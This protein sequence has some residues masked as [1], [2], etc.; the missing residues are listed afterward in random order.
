MAGFALASGCTP[1]RNAPVVAHL[2]ALPSASEGTTSAD[3][4]VADVA[5][6]LQAEIVRR[7]LAD[8]RADHERDPSTLNAVR[9]AIAY[10]EASL[11]LGDDEPWAARSFAIL[12]D[13]R[14]YASA[15]D[16]LKP[17]V[18][19]YM[20]SARALMG[21]DTR[22]IG[23]V[24][25]AFLILDDAVRVWGDTSPMPRFLR[26]SVAE[27]LPRSFRKRAVAKSDFRRLIELDAEDDTFASDKLM[28]FVLYGLSTLEPNPSTA[29]ALRAK[30]FA[31]DTDGTGATLLRSPAP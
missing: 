24:R 9:M 8:T 26:G 6:I 3:E 10:H 7:N 17:I 18:F 13:P 14:V 15:D 28:S 20:G 27:N 22:R 29:N 12:S 2:H 11:V 30:A 21:R 4:T 5:E 1:M 16:E 23:Y 19:S 31:T 25:D